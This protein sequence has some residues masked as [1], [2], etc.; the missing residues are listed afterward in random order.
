MDAIARVK[1]GRS[2]KVQE[3]RRPEMTFAQ[4]LELARQQHPSLFEP[5]GTF[6][7]NDLPGL[8]VAA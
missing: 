1:N 6:P 5:R 4:A 7:S 8:E 3:V 2:E